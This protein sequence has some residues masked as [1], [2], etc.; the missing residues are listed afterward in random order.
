MFFTEYRG[1]VHNWPASKICGAISYIHLADSNRLAPGQGH[2]HFP[3]LINTLEALDMMAGSL[4][5]F[6]LNLDRTS[7]LVSPLAT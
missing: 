2:L 3:D 7:L 4:S 5:R 6:F 1:C